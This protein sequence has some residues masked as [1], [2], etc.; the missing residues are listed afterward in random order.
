M[1]PRLSLSLA[2]VVLLLSHAAPAWAFNTELLVNSGAS[3]NRLDL[4]I[5][6]DGY[7]SED[8]AQLT[9]D[10]T[11]VV[12]ALFAEELWKRYRSYVNVKLVHVESVETGADN[13]SAG[14][15]RDTAL[16]SYFNC[17]GIDRL[18][19]AD[20]TAVL[21]AALADAPEYDQI[22]VLVNDT[23]YGGGGGQFASTS[24][25]PASVDIA[26]HEL[27]HSL[28]DLADEYSDPYPGFPACDAVNDCPEPNVS[29]FS[30]RDTNK[31]RSWIDPA[32]PLPTPDTA[33]NDGLVG[34]VEGARYQTTGVFRP[35]RDCIMRTL[36]R[37]FCPV[38]AQAG[39]LSH[40]AFTQPVDSISP[41]GLVTLTTAQTQQLKVVGPRPDPNTLRYAFSVDGVL[42]AANDTGVF[43]LNG[44]SL[45][46]GN[47]TVT[48]SITDT[49]PLVRDDPS[50]LLLASRS[51]PVVVTEAAQDFR[52]F[53]SPT[54]PWTTT[55][56]FSVQT[57]PDATNGA[58]SLQVNGCVFVPVTSP[59]FNTTELAPIDKRLALDIKL[60][61]LQPIP[62]WNG[63]LQVAV[64]I[65][66]AFLF[67]TLIG[68]VTLLN[69]PLNQWQTVYMDV[70]FWLR[71]QLAGSH[72]NARLTITLQNANCL[73]P[74]QI[75]N[76]RF[77][78]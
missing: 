77:V 21:N 47:F 50:A 32:T 40:Y 34:A 12:N 64:T 69:P 14:T 72:A 73:Q 35:E 33:A 27:G 18:I 24:I 68:N 38:C 48:V 75:D 13:G 52:S 28:F 45:G 36:G 44:S 71:P 6:G 61:S 39:V 22:V 78:P 76:L 10:A 55:F 70:P 57:V 19:C 7:R 37:H 4:V 11:T 51:W 15:T 26:V 9:R 65:P 67:Q 53:E 74:M 63:N 8:Q 59:S 1:K 58:A 31:W 25:A 29:V 66:D 54:R 49:T 16:G 30:G 56:P 62:F 3:S 41:A 42:K 43:D 20:S 2:A 23:K 46:A 5:L 17:N 60:P